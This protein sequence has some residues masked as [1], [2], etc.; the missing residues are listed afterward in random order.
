[1][2]RVQGPSGTS[3]PAGESLNLPRN[4]GDRDDPQFLGAIAPLLARKSEA[5]PWDW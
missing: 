5:R 3:G 4:A 2:S 1:M